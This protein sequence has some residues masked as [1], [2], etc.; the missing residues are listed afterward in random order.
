[1]LLFYFYPPFKLIDKAKQ[2]GYNNINIYEK[3]NENRVCFTKK[4]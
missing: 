3:I 4:R 2:V 1:M